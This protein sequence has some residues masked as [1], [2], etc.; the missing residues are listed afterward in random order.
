[1][2][3][4]TVIGSAIIGFFGGAAA[5]WAQQHILWRPQKCIEI[6]RAVFEQA[7]DALARY[8]V[9]A[10]DVEFQNTDREKQKLSAAIRLET[11]VLMQ[12]ARLQVEA[13]FPEATS[14]AYKAVLHAKIG[15]DN[16]P[17]S[18]FTE[19]SVIAI[20]MMAA[21]IGL[22]DDTGLSGLIAGVFGRPSKDATH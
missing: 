11:R 17:N 22:T 9:D 18:E 5:L 15:M 14:N 13:F 3:M 4:G 8:E 19:R 21:D 10:L 7:V 1:M 2:D 16:V 12:R 20:K 6:R